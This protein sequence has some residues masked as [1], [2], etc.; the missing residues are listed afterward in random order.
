MGFTIN[1]IYNGAMIPKEF[2]LRLLKAVDISYF[3]ETGTAGGDSVKWA[4]DHFQKCWTIELDKKQ[5]IDEVE[6]IT[7]IQGNTVDHLPSILEKDE[8]KEDPYVLFWLDAHFCDSEPN[9]TNN[10]ECYL[11]EE[12]EIISGR[13]NAVIL[14]D[15]A[16]LFAGPPPWPNDPRDWPRLDEIFYKLKLGFPEHFT[17]VVDDYIVRV[18]Q[19]LI[20]TVDAEWRENYRYRYRSAE[21]ILQESVRRSYQAFM[22]YMEINIA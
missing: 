3:I 12:I 1:E 11:I 19:S 17:T 15:D 21:T 6:G 8:F 22:N 13:K 5:L 4:K 16:R 10:K 7:Y 2:V 14:I 9:K 18:P 20:P